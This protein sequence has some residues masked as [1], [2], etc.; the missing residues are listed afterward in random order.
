[1]CVYTQIRRNALPDSGT[2][3]AI[4]ERSRRRTLWSRLRETV[5]GIAEQA[6]IEV[7][8]LDAAASGVTD[9]A[10]TAGDAA[11]G[12]LAE[13]GASGIVSSVTDLAGSADPAEIVAGATDAVATAGEAATGAV[14]EAST[15]AGGALDA[16]KGQ[17]AP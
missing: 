15:A 14:G 16:L 7:P 5:A 8:G 10:G 17:L 4:R 1:M 9:L 13:V 11:S 3:S 12:V 2:Q 6:G